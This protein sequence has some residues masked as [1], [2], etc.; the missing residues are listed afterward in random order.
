M[1]EIAESDFSSID[2]FPL[3]W[4][5]TD[6]RWNKLPLADLNEIKPLIETKADE[7]CQH[8]LQFCNQSGL[9]TSLFEQIEEV[10]TSLA[11]EEIIQQWLL[12]CSPNLN[13][14]VI[15]SWDNNR[16]V[17]VNWKVFC[18]YWDDFCYP[19]SDDVEIFPLTE[20]W[21]LSYSHSEY[22]IFGIHS[23]GHKSVP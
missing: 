20:E 1:I 13:Q 15:V 23:N 3:K 8:S 7:L 19:A 9:K 5:W 17:L 12:N 18:K 2:S 6:S 16:A 14:S 10:N 22:F 4:R 11:E 21:M